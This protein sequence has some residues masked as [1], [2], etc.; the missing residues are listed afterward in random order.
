MQALLDAAL[1]QRF[2]L[3]FE[4]HQMVVVAACIY[5]SARVLLV[6]HCSSMSCLVAGFEGVISWHCLR[7][8]A[9]N[10]TSACLQNHVGLSTI[11]GMRCRYWPRRY[12]SRASWRL[13]NRPTHRSRWR[14]FGLAQTLLVHMHYAIPFIFPTPSDTTPLM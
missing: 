10:S 11:S 14:P 9:P 1:A 13:Q 12:H 7:V 2:D 5:A 3:L 6:T 8:P 4:Q